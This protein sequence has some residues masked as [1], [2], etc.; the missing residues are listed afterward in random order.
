MPRSLHSSAGS[1]HEV[2]ISA[3]SRLAQATRGSRR[4]TLQRWRHTSH[5]YVTVRSVPLTQTAR[6]NPRPLQPGQ[7]GYRISSGMVL[8]ALNRRTDELSE[9]TV[10]LD[11]DQGQRPKRL[12]GP[13]A[14]LTSRA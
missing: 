14:L 11:Q 5:S 12:V 1:D 2:L 3:S 10:R 4:A 13:V 9:I 6:A 8:L 7:A